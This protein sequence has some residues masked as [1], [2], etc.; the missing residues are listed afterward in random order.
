MQV[1]KYHRGNCVT[2]RVYRLPMQ[3]LTPQAFARYGQVLESGKPLYPDVG[4]DAFELGL[5]HLRIKPKKITTMAFHDSYNQSFVAIEGSMV[6]LVT[7]PQKP[8]HR[9]AINYGDLAAF[10]FEPGQAALIEH[11]VGH[12]AVPVGD[13]CRFVNVTRKHRAEQKEIDDVIEG[14]GGLM[15][16]RADI[17]FVEFGKLDG[18]CIIIDFQSD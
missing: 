14:R 7:S 10:L 6:M 15:T 2:E 17:E 13:E 3:P 1:K 9:D 11:G 5:I 8:G 4:K 16:S 18:S 12:F